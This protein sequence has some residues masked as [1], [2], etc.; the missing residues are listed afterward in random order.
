MLLQVFDI[1]FIILYFVIAIALGLWKTPNLWFKKGSQSLSDYFLSKRQLPWWLAGAS[2]VATTFSADTP[3]WVAGK[4]AS[5]G[6]A[7]N[8]LWW[9]MA[10]GSLLTVFFFSRLWWRAGVLTDLELIELRYSGRSSSVLRGF[11][12]IYVGLGLNCIVIAWV[13][14]ALIRICEVIVPEYDARLLVLAS[15][16]ITLLYVSITGLR[17]IVIADAFQFIVALGGC[18][19]LAFFAWNHPAIIAKGGLQESLP[20]SLFYFIPDFNSTVAT[21]PNTMQETGAFTLPWSS[22]LVYVLVLWW[23]SWYPGSEPGGGGY[24]TQRILSARNEKHGLLS[25]LWFVIAHYCVRSWPWIIAALS[26]TA[27]YPYLKGSEQE[28]GF[29]YLIGDVLPSP[30]RGL[31]VAAFLSAYMSTLST[32]LN[33][34]ASYLIN[35]FY[36]RFFV[37]EKSEGHY[38]F[39]SRLVTIGIAICSLVIAFFWLESI[40]SAW[41]FLLDCTAGMGFV[42]ILRWYW[43]RVNAWAELT[44]IVTPLIVLLFFRWVVPAFSSYQLPPSPESMLVTVPISILSILSV[45][46]LTP[47]DNREHLRKFYQRVKPLG[48]GWYP[49]SG[50]KGKG[51]AQLFLAWFTAIILVYS[52]LFLIGNLLFSDWLQAFICLTLSLF[53]SLALFFI[54]RREFSVKVD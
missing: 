13:H 27:L 23:A 8:W 54:L 14:L 28:T 43:W 42:L 33:W 47:P 9:S 53:S 35:D 10:I 4:V 15:V 16:C 17:G 25:A 45:I 5:Q 44:S 24:I 6:I 7:A 34:G 21:A 2:M 51:L 38:I 1:L 30:W 18:V 32:H 29:V 52:S 3:L 11:K 48:P 12:A 49:I 50:S 40:Q 41:G 26:A 36:K 19:L 37:I 31:L 20:E 39:I 22:F 46:Y